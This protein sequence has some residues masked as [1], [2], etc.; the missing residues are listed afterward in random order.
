[1][2]VQGYTVNVQ[3]HKQDYPISTPLFDVVSRE[4]IEDGLGLRDAHFEMANGEEICN[5]GY[6]SDLYMSE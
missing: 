3:V 5:I 4:T 6:V 1:M 2:V